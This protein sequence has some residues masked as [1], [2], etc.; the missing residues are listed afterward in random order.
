M[1]HCDLIEPRPPEEVKVAFQWRRKLLA[2]EKLITGPI[3]HMFNQLMSVSYPLY[4]NFE[5]VSQLLFVYEPRPPVCLVQ[6]VVPEV[7][8]SLRHDNAELAHYMWYV[9]QCI[10]WSL[11]A[12]SCDI[13][14]ARYEVD[15]NFTRR[16][17][18]DWDPGDTIVTRSGVQWCQWNINGRIWVCSV[19]ADH[20]PGNR[21]K[22]LGR[23]PI[24]VP[25]TT[26]MR[27][28]SKVWFSKDLRQ[29]RKN[30]KEIK[31]RQLHHRFITSTVRRTAQDCWEN[32]W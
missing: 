26:R 15:L 27:G 5:T 6:K 13:I 11:S 2:L 32:W 29:D 8:I 31:N 1:S 18:C 7:R 21:R 20:H 10:S 16:L 12:M 28:F 3:L 25:P 30:W 24:N 19:T 14:G 23:M 4:I 22:H 17:P 9:H